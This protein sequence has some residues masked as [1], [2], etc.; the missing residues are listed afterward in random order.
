MYHQVVDAEPKD[1]HAVS[2]TAFSDQMGWLH[3]HGYEVVTVEDLFVNSE[4]LQA[5]SPSRR[6]AITIDDGYLDTLTNALP[7]L[8]KFDFTA[9]IFLVAKR[10]GGVNDWD[11]T[12][13]LRGA[14]LLTWEQVWELAGGGIGFGAHTAPIRI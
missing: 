12:P 4:T 13:S 5:G 8:Q 7:I 14:P 10:V 6:V 2:V 9:T 3:E 1:I 11:E